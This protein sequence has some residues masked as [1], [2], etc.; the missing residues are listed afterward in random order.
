MIPYGPSGGDQAVQMVDSFGYYEAEYAAIRKGVGLMDLPQRGLVEVT[1]G[2]RLDFLH[3]ILTHDMRSLR[4]GQGRRAFLLNQKG[5]ITADTIVLHDS[6]RTYLEV[7]VFQAPLLAAQLGQYLFAED[8]QLRDVTDQ[9]VHLAL[10]GPAGAAVLAEMTGEPLANLDTLD[11]RRIV[12]GD[13]ACLVFRCDDAGALGLHLWVPGQE[14]VAV[15]QNLLATIR[16]GDKVP[17]RNRQIGWSAYNTARIEAGTPIFRIDFGPDSLPHETGVLS[18]AV[19]FTK[20]CYLGQE[21]VARMEN[22]GH[23]KQVLVGLKFSDDRLPLAG[24]QVLEPVGRD[25]GQDDSA[26]QTKPGQAVSTSGSV[27]GAVTSS[28]VSPMLGGNAAAFAMIRWGMH[29]PG[30][31]VIVP[32]EGQM[33]SATVGAA[34]FL[35]RGAVAS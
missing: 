24:T 15:Y 30:T 11:H 3:R 29:E 1:G 13:H 14:A 10:H 35:E 19:S 21:I 2:D 27:I 22:L 6:D 32:A 5:R 8:V 23:P 7:D 16:R 31:T 33:V 25:K 20:G 28:C 18:Q 17:S 12:L 9:Y 34:A 4:P 26:D